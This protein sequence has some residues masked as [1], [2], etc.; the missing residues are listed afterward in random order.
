MGIYIVPSLQTPTR[1]SADSLAPVFRDSEMLL[2]ISCL[3]PA[4][5]LSWGR[6]ELFNSTG[7]GYWA[8]HFPNTYKSG[9]WRPGLVTP[10]TQTNLPRHALGVAFLKHTQICLMGPGPGTSQT[11]KLPCDALALPKHKHLPP[12]SGARSARCTSAS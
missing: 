9:P 3:P 5:S 1:R 8:S 10:R 2:N 4:S 7:T 6:R 12:D 11:Q